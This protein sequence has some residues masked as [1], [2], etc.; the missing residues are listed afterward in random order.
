MQAK[1]FIAADMRRALDMVK[2]EYGEDAMI[3]STERTVKGVELVATGEAALDQLQHSLSASANVSTP[4]MSERQQNI[5]KAAAGFKSGDKS[6]FQSGFQA[7]AADTVPQT[8]QLSQRAALPSRTAYSSSPSSRRSSENDVGPASGKTKQQLADEMELAN[9]KMQAAQQADSMTL[10]DWADKE[11]AQLQA[12]QAKSQLQSKQSRSLIEQHPQ[13]QR[14]SQSKS[15]L[16]PEYSSQLQNDAQA[17]FERQS[18]QD[19]QS[20]DNDIRRLHNEI[21]EMRE[22]LEIQLIHM[23]DMQERQIIGM[24]QIVDSNQYNVDSIQPNQPSKY[25]QVGQLNLK[26][27]KSQLDFLSLPK[28]AN[29]KIVNCLQKKPIST[30]KKSL[31]WA[32]I[33]TQVSRQIPSDTSDPV[34]QGGIYAFLGTTGVGKTTTIAKLAARYVMENGPDDVV[35]L[36]TDR[37]RIAAHNQ[38]TSLAKVLNVRVEIVDELNHLPHYLD[39]LQEYSLILIDTPGMG[40]ADPLLKPHLN[41]LK[42]CEAVQNV[43]VAPANNQYQMIK[44]SLHSYGVTNLDYCVMTKLDECATLSDATGVLIEHNLPLAYITDGQSVPEDI[45]ILKASEFVA[46]GVNLLKKQRKNNALESQRY[47]QS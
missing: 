45:A 5:A 10:E 1:R 16:V 24:D 22:T 37:H 2:E 39:Q 11:Y 14:Q 32:H 20:Q 43:F 26:R 47:S 13:E 21:A 40:H 41:I 44:A 9:R 34:S 18:R 42:Q 25:N 28:A 19:Q 6:E 38:L 36:T 12:K 27:I 4:M 17:S 23:S 8:S 15:Q 30:V 3:I 46:R 7:V 33:L 35:L 31:L 29:D